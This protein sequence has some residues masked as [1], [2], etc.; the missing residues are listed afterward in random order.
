MLLNEHLKD[1]ATAAFQDNS[2]LTDLSPEER[3]IAAQAYEQMAVE[4]RG[5]KAELARLYNL[6]RARFLRGQVSHI[7]SKARLFADELEDNAARG[8]SQTGD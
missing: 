8:A 1:L 7:A 6:E 4:V 5:T 3:E 2:K